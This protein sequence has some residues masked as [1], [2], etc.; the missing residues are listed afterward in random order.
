[1]IKWLLWTAL[2]LA[3]G[4]AFVI[5]VNADQQNFEIPFIVLACAALALGWTTGAAGWRGLAIWILLP[6]ILI[7]LAIPF[8]DTNKFTGGDDTDPVTMMVIV[9]ALASTVLILV[10]AGARSLYQRRRDQRTVA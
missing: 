8:G 9:P 4:M 3:A 7:P 1:M 10:A 2:F 5:A 6:W